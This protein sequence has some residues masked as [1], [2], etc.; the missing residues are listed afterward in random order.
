MTARQGLHGH[1][2]LV[3]AL[4]G[5]GVSTL[6]HQSFR[7]PLHISKPWLEDTTLI[8]HIV[9]QTAGLLA[10]DEVETNIR[11]ETG[12]RLLVTSPSASRAHRTPT[13]EIYLRQTYQVAAGG[14]L[15]VFPEIFI[16]QAGTTCHQH[17]R[18]E[19]SSGGSLLYIDSLA[20]GRVASGESFAYTLLDWR[21]DLLIDDRPVLRERSPLRPGAP[22]LQAL[23]DVFPNAYYATIHLVE[24]AEP[25]APAIDWTDVLA[26]Q[27]ST[28]WIGCSQIEPGVWTLRILAADSVRL[29]ETLRVV[30]SHIY[31][32]LDRPEPMLRK[33]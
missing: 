19:V 2:D 33:L 21:T 32:L 11:V 22:N 17:T 7:A 5:R 1:L 25:D 15:E 13:G 6:T 12:A 3:C 20:P 24:P 27:S 30:R 28:L 9:N 31:R 10:G 8:V 16:P 26:L 14:A 4:D 29:R 23:R 18:I